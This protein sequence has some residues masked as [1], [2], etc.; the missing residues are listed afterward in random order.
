[1]MKTITDSP[2]GAELLDRKNTLANDLGAVWRG[3]L[4]E[5]FRRAILAEAE[6]NKIDLA[7]RGLTPAALSDL[8][9]DGLE[10]MKS[11]VAD[12]G[13][14]REAARRLVQVIALAVGG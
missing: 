14:Q 3:R 9:L 2:H 8:L 5:M 11:R 4:S 10:G 7:A 1:M 12:A 13:E 6:S